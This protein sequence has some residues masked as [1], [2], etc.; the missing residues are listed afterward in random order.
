MYEIQMEFIPGNNQIWVAQLNE[1][2][3]IYKYTTLMEAEAKGFELE[4][5]DPS[6]RRY[7]V[8]LVN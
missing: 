8:V 5:D 3:P 7:R 6:G 2:D 4:N 1:S